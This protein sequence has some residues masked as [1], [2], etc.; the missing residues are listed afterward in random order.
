[1]NIIYLLTNKRNKK[2]IGSKQEC[3]IITLDGDNYSEVSYKLEMTVES[4][5]RYFFRYL[6]SILKSEDIK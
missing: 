1:M 3:Q 2:N 6:R 4:A 5:K